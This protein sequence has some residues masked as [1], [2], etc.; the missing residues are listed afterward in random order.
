MSYYGLHF[1]TFI[2]STKASEEYGA[3]LDVSVCYNS[4]DC[5][6]DPLEYC[7]YDKNIFGFCEKCSAVLRSCVAQDFFC[8]NGEK[9]CNET[10]GCKK[11]F[12]V[13]IEYA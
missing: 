4:S 9:S 3:S 6:K 10:C 8:Y 2:L 12:Y 13:H 11:N 1:S 5:P 7:N